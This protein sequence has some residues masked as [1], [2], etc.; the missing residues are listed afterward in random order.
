MPT[1]FFRMNPFSLGWYLPLLVNDLP[2]AL[3]PS[4]RGIALLN[5]AD[6]ASASPQKRSRGTDK[7]SWQDLDERFRRDLPDAIYVGRL[8]F[9]GLV[10]RACPKLTI[11]DGVVVSEAEREKSSKLLK[12]LERSVRGGKA[13]VAR[14][15]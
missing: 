14:R 10:M 4:E 11:L 6:T 15:K 2:G 8:G 5:D 13:D 12:G 1:L 9:R 7:P 3:Q